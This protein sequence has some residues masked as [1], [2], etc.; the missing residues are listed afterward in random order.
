MEKSSVTML[1]GAFVALMIGVSL[2]GVVATQGNEIT[3]TITISGEE[4][5]YTS[6]VQDNG[7]INSSVEFSINSDNIPDGWRINECPISS[8]DLY[9][10]S[11]SLT[12]T[13]DYTF[14]TVTGVITFEN[15]GNV[16]GTATNVTTATYVY[17]G[18]EYLT[19]GWNRT[20]I[21]LVPGFFA[22]ALMGVG[23]G[24]FYSVMKKEGILGM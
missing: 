6:A 5:D 16:N 9:N 18:K 17:C 21:N 1:I 4:I 24:L 11:S 22:L 19:Q 2:V 12:L 10:S 13:T 14:D 8:F 20:I 23:V 7:T 15:S 3:N